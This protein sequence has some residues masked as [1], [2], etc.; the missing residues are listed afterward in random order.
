[1]AYTKETVTK[2]RDVADDFQDTE[3]PSKVG[4]GRDFIVPAYPPIPVVEDGHT[5]QHA[6]Y[7]K[8]VLNAVDTFHAAFMSEHDDNDRCSFDDIA[9]LLHYIADLAEADF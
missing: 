1:M 4:L 2:L 3:L 8:K 9:A 5:R 7:R 6:A